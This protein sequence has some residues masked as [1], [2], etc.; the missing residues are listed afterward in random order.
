M[1]TLTGPTPAPFTGSR[2]TAQ[3]FL[4]EFT[5]LVRANLSHILII[6][7]ELRVELALQ[8]ITQNSTTVAW[9]RSAHHQN[10]DSG[11][12]DETVWDAFYDSFCTAWTDDPAPIPATAMPPPCPVP[13]SDKIINLTETDLD[14]WALSAPHTKLAQTPPH[15]PRNPRP[16]SP[17]ASLLDLVKPV[18]EPLRLLYAPV[19]PA[20]VSPVSASAA[21]RAKGP[22][23]DADGGAAVSDDKDSSYEGNTPLLPPPAL[24]ASLVTPTSVVEGD[25]NPERRVK[26]LGTSVFAPDFTLSHPVSPVLPPQTSVYNTYDSPCRVMLAPIPRKRPREPDYTADRD[27]TRRARHHL[28]HPP[29]SH[30][31]KTTRRIVAT[32]YRNQHVRHRPRD[33]DPGAMRKSRARH[34][35]TDEERHRYLTAQP[36]SL[37]YAE[38]FPRHTFEQPRDPDEVAPATP[39]PV[40]QRRRRMNAAVTVPHPPT[41]A[42]PVATQSRASTTANTLHRPDEGTTRNRDGPTQVHDVRLASQRPASP[43]SNHSRAHAAGTTSY[44]RNSEAPHNHDGYAYTARRHHA[45]GIPHAHQTQPRKS[46]A[47]AIDRPA[48]RNSSPRRSTS[49]AI[50]GPHQ[51]RERPP[52]AFA[53]RRAIDTFLK[54]YDARTVQ[55][56]TPTEDD[57][58]YDTVARYLDRWLWMTDRRYQS[59]PFHLQ[60]TVVQHATIEPRQSKNSKTNDAGLP[61]HSQ[62]LEPRAHTSNTNRH[63][64]STRDPIADER[65]DHVLRDYGYEHRDA[66]RLTRSFEDE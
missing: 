22:Q 30:L 53:K 45:T 2:E 60:H 38:I 18:D 3:T 12:T 56:P 55:K 10:R 19:H 44:P 59:P 1:Q 8:F 21:L 5:Q 28:D 61:C 66:R 20:P 4:D 17:T 41:A 9:K 29:D 7:P 33:H 13:G 49:L 24:A 65:A 50:C 31:M 14:E 51:R 15:P 11:L 39:L 23:T 32:K 40:N 16:A 63:R 36:Q 64:T 58:A 48:A 6:R 42:P 57:H 27:R 62:Q 37:R 43:A 34:A 26:T 25:N 54:D 47:T 35:L 52:D 46:R